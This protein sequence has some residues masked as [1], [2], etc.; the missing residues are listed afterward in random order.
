[1]QSASGGGGDIGHSAVVFLYL[2]DFRLCLCIGDFYFISYLIE[3]GM[4]SDYINI[5]NITFSPV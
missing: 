5:F 2:V 1:M 3:V 4:P